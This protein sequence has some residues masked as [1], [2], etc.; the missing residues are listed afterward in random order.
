M[1]RTNK[2]KNNIVSS[3]R[4]HKTSKITPRFNP[5]QD[6]ETIQADCKKEGEALFVLLNSPRVPADIKYSLEKWFDSFDDVTHEAQ[7]V[8]K[9]P[10]R[11]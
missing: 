10:T 5:P 3:I 8:L 11:F 1:S 6:S 4:F 9:F 7:N 2:P